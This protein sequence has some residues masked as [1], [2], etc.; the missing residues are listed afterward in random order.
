MF[1]LP[2]DTPPR[3]LLRQVNVHQAAA[4]LLVDAVADLHLG[5]FEV[6]V[7]DAAPLP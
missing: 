3:F 5:P 6:R 7:F 4:P 1:Q 2:A